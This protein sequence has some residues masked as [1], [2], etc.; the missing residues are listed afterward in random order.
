MPDII[1]K[2]DE[3]L[4]EKSEKNLSGTRNSNRHSLLRGVESFYVTGKS[5]SMFHFLS[6]WWKT[7]SCEWVT[8]YELFV[9]G[10]CLQSR[11]H[12]RCLWAMMQWCRSRRLSDSP[13]IFSL[14]LS[15]LRFCCL[16]ANTERM[17]RSLNPQQ[18][19]C[20]LN[21]EQ[22]LDCSSSALSHFMHIMQYCMC[23]FILLY[24]HI[25]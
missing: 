17:R 24:I 9:R 15:D 25:L 23:F 7:A 6:F 20:V 16:R 8:Q 13:T 19:I 10:C 22:L 12:H 2:T 18:A 21:S 1:N 3:Q 5:S 4:R 14:L 11:G